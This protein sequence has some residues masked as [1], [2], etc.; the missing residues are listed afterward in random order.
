MSQ[1]LLTDPSTFDPCLS[2]VRRYETVLE[3]SGNEEEDKSTFFTQDKRRFNVKT[4]E[5][6]LTATSTHS[7]PTLVVLEE[8]VPQTTHD[9]IRLSILEPQDATNI[10]LSTTTTSSN[11]DDGSASM[12][13]PSTGS[14]SEQLLG[15]VVDRM[16]APGVRKDARISDAHPKGASD[17]FVFRADAG[18]SLFFAQWLSPGQKLTATLKYKVVWPEE[19]SIY[20][21]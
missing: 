7:R 19:R 15:V 17:L 21:R 9:D 13:S 14:L 3:R 5:A 2:F 4:H 6:R 12:Y 11:V 18:G 8:A 16:Y 20:I 10:S 1:S